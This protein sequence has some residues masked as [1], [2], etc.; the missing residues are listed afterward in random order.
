[1][2]AVLLI[3]LGLLLQSAWRSSIQ[4][5]EALGQVEY[6]QKVLP[7]LH[8]YCGDCHGQKTSEGRWSFD[9]YKSYDAARADQALWQKVQQYVVSHV[10][11]PVDA[12]QPTLDER[13]AILRWID[14]SV[15]YVDPARPDPGRT[16]LRRLNR[17]EYRNTIRD[18]LGVDTVAVEHFPADDAGYGFD[19]IG[20]VLTL[21]PL[22]FEKY[23]QAARDIAREVTN[24]GSPPRVGVER[25]ADKLISFR[26]DRGDAERFETVW[27]LRSPQ[28]EVGTMVN[29]AETSTYRVL[30]RAAVG[31]GPDQQLYRLQICCDGEVLGELQPNMEWKGRAQAYATAFQLVRLP[32]GEHRMTLRAVGPAVTEPAPQALAAITFLGIAGPF[33]PMPPTS[34]PLFRETF[35]TTRF[36]TP[37]LRLSGEDLDAG[38]GRSSLDTGRAWFASNGYRRAP[39]L[40]QQAGTYRVRFKVGAQQVGDEPV[41][42]EIRLP[43]QTLGPFSVTA[44]S[45]AEQWIEAKCELTPGELDWQVWFVNEFKDPQTGAERWFWLHEFTIEGPL[46]QT[47][48]LTRDQSLALLEKVGMRLFRRP[49]DDSQ[50][51]KIIRLYDSV[52]AT[53]T[54]PNETTP[55]E[56]TPTKTTPSEA[57]GVVLESLLVSPKF[58][59]HPQ[60]RIEPASIDQSRGNQR[61]SDGTAWVDSF[62]LASRLAYFLWSSAPDEQLLDLAQRGQLRARWREQVQRM[63][64]DPKSAALT[65]NFAG[66]WLLLRNLDTVKPDPR[67]FPEFDPQL[68]ADMRRE[69]ELF[70]SHTLQEN[71]PVYAFLDADYTFLNRRLARHYGLPEPE[72]DEFQRYSL[73]ASPRRGLLTH[74]SILTLTSH[75][76]R[77]SPVKRGKWLLEQFLGSTPPPAPADVPPFPEA[78]DDENLS[79]RVRF[80]QHRAQAACA[81]CHA[82]LDPPGFALENYDAIGRWRH[83]DGSQPIDPRGQL[84]TGEKF[85]DWSELRK[86][87]S[88]DRRPDF[89][90]CFVEHLLTYA[91]GRGLTYHDKLAVQEILDRSRA[92]DHRFQDLILTLTESVPFQRMRAD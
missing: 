46:Q 5:E 63:I 91:L 80:E 12:K 54:T 7:L 92:T 24:L 83:L 41:R 1:M 53:E 16:T 55:T 78:Q 52:L 4:A 48:E 61:L 43:E 8:K 56:T 38:T 9:A 40:I 59:Y 14:Q 50:R 44:P 21:S 25:I 90:R 37:I 89:A 10:M 57:F 35:P 86:I 47:Q 67:L 74:A 34:S 3:T 19:N 11:P 2:R 15:F 68:A 33:T 81:A 26:D 73:A 85:E 70:F 72:T 66:Q 17:A 84:V 79:L 27:L 82:Y 51:Q 22:H 29:V 18:V 77:T 76:T 28:A 6:E 49:L 36:G 42:F 75:P 60:P 65:E 39:V 58:L 13:R 71:L 30:T 32:R 45:Q 88:Q 62:T 23:L 20:D 69:T 31:R 64:A 87:L